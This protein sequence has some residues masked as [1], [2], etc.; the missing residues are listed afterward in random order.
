[1]VTERSF[2]THSHAC[3]WS[4]SVQT[5]FKNG[6]PWPAVSTLRKIKIM[7]GILKPVIN[8]IKKAEMPTCGKR[9]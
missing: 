7:P 2:T 6:Y 4:Q 3:S 9:K 5:N 1:M 8:V